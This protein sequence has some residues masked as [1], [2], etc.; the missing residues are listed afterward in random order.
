MQ[1]YLWFLRGH[2]ELRDL[3]AWNSFAATV[4]VS[5]RPPWQTG[6]GAWKPRRL[7]DS[8]VVS[9]TGWLE[10][11]GL[12][13]KTNETGQA[14]VTVSQGRAYN[15]IV[16]YL[17]RLK[18]D[19]CPRLSGGMW[20]GSKIESFPV[21]YLG[22][23][24]EAVYASM[25]KRFFVGAVARA[26]RPGCKHDSMIILEGAQG[27]KKSA[28][29]NALAT[30]DGVSYFTDSVADIEGKDAALQMQGVWIAEIAELNALNRKDANAIK[31]WLSR[32]VDRFRPPYGK[33]VQDF[34]RHTVLAGTVNPT[35]HGYLKDPTGWRRFWPVPISAIDL[36]AVVRDRDQLWAEA[37]V[38]YQRGEPHYMQEAEHVA[39]EEIASERFEDD[40]WAEIIDDYIRTLNQVSIREIIRAMGIP[41]ERQNSLVHK[42]VAEHLKRRHWKRARKRIELHSTPQYVFVRTREEDAPFAVSED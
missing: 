31:A 38:L 21:S 30:I 6:N 7:N 32:Q 29:L 16:D 40:P 23:P 20:E 42:R 12:S 36:E 27:K 34:P 10:K 33:N 3:F 41:P 13:P 24:D 37:V 9:A 11:F 18:W 22:S 14:V 4:Y 1:N 15:P 19:G 17:Q 28:V 39:A 5:Q 25:T 26:V 8:D 35:G 2:D